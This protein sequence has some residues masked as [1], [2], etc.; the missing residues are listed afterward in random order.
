MGQV[1]HERITTPQI[2][3]V[4][5]E[6]YFHVS[7]FEPF[8]PRSAWDG[9]ASRVEAAT[10]RVLRL[11]ADA[12]AHGTFFTL[13]WVA[14]RHPGLVRR[15]VDAGHEIGSHSWWHRRIPTLTPEEFRDDVRRSKD[16]LEQTSGTRVFGFRA[17]SF[18]IRPG[19]AWALDV[20]RDVG[21]VYDSSFFPIRRPGYGYPGAPRD[22]HLI[23]CRTGSL[24]ELPLAT[25]RWAGV[26]LPGAGGGYLRQLPFGLTRRAF[27]EHAARGASAVF[28]TH[29]W[30]L[31][32]D[33]PR[34]AVPWLTRVRHYRGLTRT[35]PRIAALLREFRFTSVARRY[36]LDPARAD[37]GV[38]AAAVPAHA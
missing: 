34:L 5:V 32:V 31:D 20:L 23:P 25:T 19:T 11:L 24:L 21:F 22:P 16:V 33:Q 10:D 9:F 36:G 2:F 14:E 28:Y 13:G 18:S 4:D 35:A 15:I 7:A 1:L 3:T 27:R 30:E 26:R 29:P 37:G 8:V 6:E 17:P 38:T 12:G